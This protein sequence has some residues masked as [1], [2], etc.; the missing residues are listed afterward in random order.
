VIELYEAKKIPN[1]KTALNLSIKLFSP[2]LY[3]KEDVDKSYNDI[4]NKYKEAEPIIGRLK[5]EREK[6]SRKKYECN[7]ILY[8]DTDERTSKDK[9]SDK[10]VDAINEM[11]D[12]NKK[13]Y[14]K[15][16]NKRFHGLLQFHIGPFNILVNDSDI[17]FLSDNVHKFIEWIVQTDDGKVIDNPDFDR[18]VTILSTDNDF[19]ERMKK[20]CRISERVLHSRS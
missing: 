15:Y 17:K 20:S 11:S 5:R 7:V 2:S 19:E 12:E 9:V 10:Y 16:L 1:F 13:K 3:K 8:R 18:M 4:I 6:K 14:R